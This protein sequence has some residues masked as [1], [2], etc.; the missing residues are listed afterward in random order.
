MDKFLEHVG[1]GIGLILLA[2]A[3]IL[4]YRG[5][6]R[7]DDCIVTCKGEVAASSPFHCVC[8]E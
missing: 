8:K 6:S 2:L 4:L 3:L 7:T 1:E 5:C